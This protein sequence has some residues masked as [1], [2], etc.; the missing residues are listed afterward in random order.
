MSLRKSRR[1]RTKLTKTKAFSP[2]RPLQDYFDTDPLA[3]DEDN[4]VPARG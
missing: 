4:L 1:V 2:T 3:I